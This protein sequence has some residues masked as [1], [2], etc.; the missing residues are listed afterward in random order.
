MVVSAISSVVEED[1]LG[2]CGASVL[3]P[4]GSF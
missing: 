4:F 3:T 2:L 1:D